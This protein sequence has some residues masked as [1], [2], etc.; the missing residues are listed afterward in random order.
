MSGIDYTAGFCGGEE[1][2]HERVSRRRIAVTSYARIVS[3]NSKEIP[4]QQPTPHKQFSQSQSILQ[5]NVRVDV[6]I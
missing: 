2:A 4:P 1:A 5:W 3:H 6:G